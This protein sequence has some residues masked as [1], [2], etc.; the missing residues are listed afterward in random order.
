MK[1]EA[2]VL[3]ERN[4][5]SIWHSAEHH[6]YA[7]EPVTRVPQRLR[8]P[9]PVGNDPE[10]PRA[11]WLRPTDIVRQEMARRMFY[12]AH[13]VRSILHLDYGF[14]EPA[15]RAAAEDFRDALR[16]CDRAQPRRYIEVERIA[17]SL[18]F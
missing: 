14:E 9:E 13:T 18:Q 6:A 3:A 5:V 17:C 15:L 12:E 8:V 7:A 4:S 2:G 10:I 1:A 16:E 11:E